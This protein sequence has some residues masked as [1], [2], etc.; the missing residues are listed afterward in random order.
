MRC[1][2]SKLP[3]V[4]LHMLKVNVP[5]L[6]HSLFLIPQ[7]NSLCSGSNVGGRAWHQLCSGKG[8]HVEKDPFLAAIGLS[9]KETKGTE[10]LC[11]LLS[12]LGGWWGQW[13]LC[14]T[15]CPCSTSACIFV[16][17][18]QVALS[19]RAQTGNFTDWSMHRGKDHSWAH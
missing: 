14:C 10:T 4:P 5:L 17:T 12:Q 9:H 2:S 6:L 7:P 11:R 19:F 18:F 1:L 15:D 13:Q 16:T 3:L 8:F